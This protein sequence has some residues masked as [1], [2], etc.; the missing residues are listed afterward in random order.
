MKTAK[1]SKQSKLHKTTASQHENDA[2]GVEWDCNTD[3]L[4][5]EDAYRKRG[6]SLSF[7]VTHVNDDDN[8]FSNNTC[9]AACY[10]IWK[11]HY[12]ECTPEI[13]AKVL[14]FMKYLVTDS[15]WISE[16]KKVGDI[17]AQLKSEVVKTKELFKDA[18]ELDD[19]IAKYNSRKFIHATTIN[20]KFNLVSVAKELRSSGVKVKIIGG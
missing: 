2:W 18:G 4:D 11:N 17:H 16:M 14:N 3:A 6:R 9:R 8:K 12:K 19:E 13:A 1:A 20:E 7:L 5:L 15:K 10:L